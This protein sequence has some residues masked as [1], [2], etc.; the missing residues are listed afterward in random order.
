MQQS[1]MDGGEAILQAC[2]DL[3]A[4]YIIS[5]PGSDWGAVW[6]A[7]ARQET[8]GCPGPRYL[9]C[10]HETLAV[11]IAMG[12]TVM[13]G[14]MQ[15]V[16][17]HAGVGLLQGAVAIHGARVNDLP[18]LVMSGES[19]TYGDDPSFDPGPQWYA[20]HNAMGGLPRAID[21]V[22]KWAQQAG[23]SAN[24]YEMVQRA[25][26]LAMASPS[27][28]TYLD[29]PI[30]IMM[31]AWTPPAKRRAIPMPARLRPA[32]GEIEAALDAILAAREPVITTAALGRS[33]EAYAALIEL[34]EILAL[35]VLESNNA[36][37]SNFPK[38]H[39]LYQGFETAALLKQ[40]DLVLV[41]NSRNPWYPPNMGPV[42]GRVITI[43]DSPLKLHMAY[44]NLQS[45]LYLGGDVAETLRLLSAAAR[46]RVLPQPALQ[47][48]LTRWSAA[49]EQLEQRLRKTER[50]AA[51]LPGIRPAA[52]C[53]VLSEEMPEDTIFL[54]ETTVHGAINRRHLRNRGAQSFVALRSGLGQGMGIALGV[55]LARPR[56]PVL[57]C[58][59]DGAF[60][61]NPAVQA[62][63]F[64][65]DERLPI[66]LVIYNNNGYRAMRENQLSYY[67]QGAGAQQQ[68]FLGE[69]ING[70]DFERL[71]AL[72]DGVG[73]KVETLAQL[74]QA[75]QQG[76][77]AL[78]EGRSVLINALLSEEGK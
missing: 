13:T 39:A 43:D 60:L 67:P 11:N 65:R 35:P 61:Y 68:R 69:P 18:I 32:Q 45:D 15:V 49:H 72:F 55:K 7:L 25:G 56:Q 28:P 8:G 38:S 58:I 21:A 20:N 62:L 1:V 12:Y 33:A 16:L 74:R 59:G 41:I 63:G 37:A 52:L 76:C 71:P 42:Q 75:L 66:M 4:D 30:E 6:E 3:G 9:S 22:V 77:A 31:H 48:R 23:S 2:R 54:D 73:F 19:T 14:R 47:A 64:A 70:F 10:G 29:V 24:V 44:Q 57:L 53:A 17:L 51:A 26:E 34:A 40:A 27:G 36:S 5:S 46:A 78:A 50:E